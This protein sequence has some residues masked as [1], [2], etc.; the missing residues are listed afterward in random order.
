[1]LCS[2]DDP[3]L[4]M[5]AREELEAAEADLRESDR[6][7]TLLLLPR[8]PDDEHG[9]VV[10][11]RAC[12]GGE[13]A[14]LFA[15]DIFRMYSM[16]CASQG[17]EISVVS[18]NRTDLG[19]FRKLVFTADGV[20]VWSKLKFESGV[21]EVKRVPVTESSGRIQ[22]ST[23]SVAVMPQP[24]DIDVTLDQKDILFESCKSSGA[25][26]QHIN[27]TESAVRLTHVPTGIVI[28]CQEERSQLQNREKA[29]RTLYAMLY[30]RERRERDEKIS[31]ERR[32]LI[33]T[34]DRSERIRVYRFQE[35]LI[36]DERIKYKSPTLAAFLNGDMSALIDALAAYDTALKLKHGNTTDNC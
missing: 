22:T 31:S 25:G 34:G 29:M 13:E 21:H 1:L 24:D 12:A 28:E 23:V 35:N 6:R 33:G 32:S 14:C 8:D 9:V 15:A 20:G 27:K 26:G 19:G 3:E 4:R 2:S 11:I 36:C 18:A 30:D 17:F 5:L 10:E 16:Y 7:L